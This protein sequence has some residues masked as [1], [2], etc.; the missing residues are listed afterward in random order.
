M[1]YVKA[2]REEREVGEMA[3][4]PVCGM[5]IAESDA[6]ETIEHEGT[7]YYFCSKDCADSFREDPDSYV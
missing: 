2:P 1:Y 3:K 4:D 5:E 7:T 6:V